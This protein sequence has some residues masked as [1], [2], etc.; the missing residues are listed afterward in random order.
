MKPFIYCFFT[1]IATLYLAPPPDLYSVKNRD[2]AEAIT[3]EVP[4][5]YEDLP[6]AV[7]K[8]LAEDPYK[9]WKVTGVFM[10]QQ[11]KKLFRIE[12]SR[13]KETKSVTMDENG[14]QQG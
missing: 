11:G 8:K 3:Q 14:N 1:L 2:E 4:I 12:L 10:A 13:N 6:Q 9:G 7:K 5:K